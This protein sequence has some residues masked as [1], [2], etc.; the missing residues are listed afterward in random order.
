MSGS[1]VSEKEIR[2]ALL[3]IDV[4]RGLFEKS[5]PV[6]NAEQLIDNVNT[7]INGARHAGAPVIFMQH[8]NEGTLAEG[9]EA[10]RLHPRIQPLLTEPIILKRHGNAFEETVLQQELDARRIGTL[11]IA[12]LVTHGCVRA[13]CLGAMALGYKVILVS[14]GHSSWSKKAA[15]LI[16]EWNE[17]L[18]QLGA[19]LKA[20][21]ETDFCQ[22]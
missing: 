11:V 8:A 7:L 12:G 6:H 17:K 22:L 19:R 5:T 1:S 3:V 15:K 18:S 2:A 4:Q 9:S 20:T 16:E 13:T 21:G 10:W 14:D